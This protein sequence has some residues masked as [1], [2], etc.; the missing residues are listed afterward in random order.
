MLDIFIAESAAVL[1]HREPHSMATGFVVGA[2]IFGVKSINRSTTFYTDRHLDCTQVLSGWG[3][4]GYAL[5]IA[6]FQWNAIMNF[7]S[8]HK[9]ASLIEFISF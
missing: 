2:R 6:R 8:V 4:S 7:W 9:A 5:Q 1:A 3:I